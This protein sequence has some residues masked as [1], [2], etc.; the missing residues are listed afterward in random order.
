MDLRRPLRARAGFFKLQR[1]A[2]RSLP[3][4]TRPRGDRASAN[5]PQRCGRAGATSHRRRARQRRDDREIE[6]E[7]G[8][9]MAHRAEARRMRFRRP[10]SPVASRQ[11]RPFRRAIPSRAGEPA[12]RA[13]RARSSR[14]RHAC[15]AA[16]HAFSMPNRLPVSRSHKPGNDR[17]SG[18]TPHCG[19]SNGRW[20]RR[21]P[22]LACA[23]S[24]AHPLGIISSATAPSRVLAGSLQ[25]M[26]PGDD[27]ARRS[28]RPPQ[29]VRR[30]RSPKLP[31]RYR[32][33]CP[34]AE[35]LNGG[36]RESAAPRHFPGAGDEVARTGVIAETRPFGENVFVACLRRA[37]R[38]SA[39]ARRSARTA[40]SPL[41]R[42]S[43]AA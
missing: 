3:A 18:Q 26:Q 37:P 34:A 5:L 25:G 13:H 42:W 23:K 32:R 16:A 31:P 38:S 10:H 15:A 21:D 12:R 33:R 27:A 41:R 14:R 39:S 28:C 35:Q 17:A 7:M 9:D 2:V 20:S 19:L 40:E 24:P 11:A 8:E 6:R 36:G 22:S 29:R 4:P 1:G 43:A 30:T